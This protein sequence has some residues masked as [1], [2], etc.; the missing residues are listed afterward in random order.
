MGSK[1]ERKNRPWRWGCHPDRRCNGQTLPWCDSARCRE[2]HQARYPNGGRRLSPFGKAVLE[3]QTHLARAQTSPSR[4]LSRIFGSRTAND[5]NWIDPGFA[6]AWFG[7]LPRASRPMDGCRDFD[8]GPADVG[9]VALDGCSDIIWK[10]KGGGDVGHSGF[11][12]TA[13]S[14]FAI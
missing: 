1:G 9:D 4:I 6:K 8:Q 5:C 10:T 14:F 12:S 3:V 2:R 7:P 13:L 11:R